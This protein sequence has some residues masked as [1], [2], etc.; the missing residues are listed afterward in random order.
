MQGTTTPKSRGGTC[1]TPDSIVGTGTVGGIYAS[2]AAKPSPKLTHG[3]QQ[4][5]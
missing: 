4:V 5:G 3:Q 1:G 2:E